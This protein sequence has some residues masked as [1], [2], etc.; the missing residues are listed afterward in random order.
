VAYFGFKG[1]IN[2][3]GI[4]PITEAEIASII[5]RNNALLGKTS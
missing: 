1:M 4:E 5:D 3:M 2:D